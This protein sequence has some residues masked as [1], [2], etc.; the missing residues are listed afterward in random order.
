MAIKKSVRLVDETIAVCNNLTLSGDVNWSGSINAMAEQFN[1]IIE[2]NTPELTGKEW[3]AFYCVHNGYMPH[4]SIK[5]EADILFWHISE[6]YEHDPEVRNCLGSKEAA[7]ALIERVKNWST[8]QRI[9]VIYK[10][11]AFWRK[12]PVIG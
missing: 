7:L 4:P 10:A 2:D 8:S 11:R 3:D 6:G 1:L 5:Q 12:G 9:A